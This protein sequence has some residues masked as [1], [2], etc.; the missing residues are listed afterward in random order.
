MFL[1]IVIITVIVMSAAVIVGT[2]VTRVRENR[3]AVIEHELSRTM[4]WMG[5]AVALY[6]L[7]NNGLLPPKWDDVSRVK[8]LEWIRDPGAINQQ[9]LD[10]IVYVF[11]DTKDHAG[12]GTEIIAHEALE[13]CGYDVT[14]LLLDGSVVGVNPDEM[15]LGLSIRQNAIASGNPNVVMLYDVSVAKPTIHVEQR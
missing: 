13:G 5:Q 7:E 6:R 8:G 9:V 2:L 10:R 14:V 12:G 4:R 11:L 3:A 1:T 15:R